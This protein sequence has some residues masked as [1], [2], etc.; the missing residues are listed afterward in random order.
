MFSFSTCRELTRRGIMSLLFTTACWVLSM[1]PGKQESGNDCWMKERVSC[2]ARK[3][4][5]LTLN[6]YDLLK[7]HKSQ[8]WCP[9]TKSSSSLSPCHSATLWKLIQLSLCDWKLCFV[10]SCGPYLLFC[11]P[12][13]LLHSSKSAVLDSAWWSPYAAPSLESLFSFGISLQLSA[14]TCEVCIL[15]PW[16]ALSP[17]FFSFSGNVT[18]LPI[19][20]LENLE[21]ISQHHC[22][23]LPNIQDNKMLNIFTVFPLSLTQVSW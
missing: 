8:P 9:H 16:N 4:F 7:Y 14:G 1:V 13:L 17:A 18:L 22:S 6:F 20:R 21:S 5:S 11:A 19:T 15:K 23:C 3:V 12:L 10:G 2:T